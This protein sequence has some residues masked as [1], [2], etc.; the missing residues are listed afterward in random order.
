MEKKTL[1]K[2]NANKKT[3][4]VPI[5]N[6][7]IQN[8]PIQNVYDYDT[9]VY[10]TERKQ[11]AEEN[12]K[13]ELDAIINE[14]WIDDKSDMKNKERIVSLL[15]DASFWNESLISYIKTGTF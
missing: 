4:N 5:Q 7:P 6:V 8:V 3:T 12:I 13:R 1:P 15:K 10:L 9:F 14:L 11:N 2:T